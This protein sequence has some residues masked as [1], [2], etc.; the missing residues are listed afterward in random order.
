MNQETLEDLE[1]PAILSLLAGGTT[2]PQ[3]TARALATTPWT[4]P[5][6]ILAEQALTL[7]AADYLELR[8]AL[9]F[10]TLVDLDPILDSL[11]LAGQDLEAAEVTQV[12]DLMRA[13][14]DTKGTLLR[15]RERFPRLW[16]AARDLPDLGN[17]IRFLDGKIGPRG[18]IL[19]HASDDLTSIRRELRRAGARLDGLLAEISRRPEVAKALQDDYVA[20]RSDR[21]VL[22]IRVEARPALPG[23]VHALSGTGA[24]VFIEPMETVEIN[25]EVVTLR[26]AESAEVRRLLREYSDL[27]RGR[28]AEVRAVS[29]GVGRLDLILARARLGRAMQA[30]PARCDEAGGVRFVGARHPLVEASLR[31]GGGALV[32]LDIDLDP[33]VPVLVISGPNTGGKTVALKTLGLLALMHQSG[34]LLP[35]RE[36]ALPVFASIWLDIGD[37]QSIRD[38]LSTFSARMRTIATIAAALALPALVLLDEIGTGT[39]PGEGTALGIAIVDYFR[40]RGAR[41]LAST[42]LEALKAHAA[43]T[44]GCANAAMQFDDRSGLPTYRLAQG[45]PGRSSAL[46]IAERLGLPREVIDEARARRGGEAGL[47]DEYRERLERLSRE[48]ADRL[49]EATR[50]AGELEAAQAAFD[51][52]ARS[53]EAEARRTAAAAVEAAVTAVRAEG[54]RYLA[55]LED[56]ALAIRLQRDEDRLAEGLKAEARRRLREAAPAGVPAAVPTAVAGARVRVRGL[57][58]PAT[59]EQ[60]QGDRVTLIVEGKRLQVRSADCE[61]IE[62]AAAAAT[63]LP[64]GVTLTRAES[65][66][67]V[68]LDVRGLGVDE[69]IERV[70]KFI[71]DATLEGRDRV[72]LVHGVGTGRLRQAIRERLEGHPLVGG[73]APAEPRDGGEG[74]T[75]VILRDGS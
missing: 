48:A 33:A 41:V 5:D 14:R 47:L 60:V 46:E 26:E 34:L 61:P 24:T 25:N 56:R 67:R 54:A 42:H 63:R 31:E 30:V 7:E 3:G 16:D 55:A 45:V 65:T 71:D 12:I 40:R 9:P 52:A 53:R 69:A 66:A 57:R 15:D 58:M 29:A 2:T 51:A 19:D 28:L 64:Q 4:E 38:H 36:A 35:A 6:Q 70:E 50:R 1:Y 74:A 49:D 23:I 17:L 44:P 10:G 68:D 72:R 37:R 21:H 62:A 11:G 22:P 18:E 39:D 73:V 32:P 59:I 75:W 43:V 27:I 8:G 20:L 13:G